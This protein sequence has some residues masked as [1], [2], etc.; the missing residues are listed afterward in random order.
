MIIKL[1]AIITEEGD[2][3]ESMVM[4]SHSFINLIDMS[5]S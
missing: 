1:L 3:S 5:D 2:H 4:I